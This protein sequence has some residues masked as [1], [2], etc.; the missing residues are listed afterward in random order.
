MTFLGAVNAR[1]DCTL[2]FCGLIPSLVSVY[3]SYSV[4]I[5]Q[6]D[7]LSALILNPAFYS[8][9]NTNLS[10]CVLEKRPNMSRCGH[11]PLLN[12]PEAYPQAPRPSGW[13]PRSGRPKLKIALWIGDYFKIVSYSRQLFLMQFDRGWSYH[14]DPNIQ[15]KFPKISRNHPKSSQNSFPPF[16]S[17]SLQYCTPTLL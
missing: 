14:L 16:W 12:T 4:V 6:N 5:A 2:L 9:R 3:P 8:F 13:R 10:F 11:L 15:V 7:N 17:T 1:I